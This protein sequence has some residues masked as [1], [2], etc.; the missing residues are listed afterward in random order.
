MPRTTSAKKA[1]RQSETR[2]VRNVRRKRT[3]RDALKKMEKALAGKDKGEA[4]KLLPFAQKSLDKAVKNGLL[5]KNTASRV[6]SKL[7]AALKKL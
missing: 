5:K 7:A 2:R 1:L 3:L 4:Q 6:K